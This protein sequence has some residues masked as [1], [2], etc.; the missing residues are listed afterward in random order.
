M[1]AGDIKKAKDAG[2]HTCNGMI[3][4]TKK[5]SAW[6]VRCLTALHTLADQ[7]GTSQLCARSQQLQEIKGLSEAKV[8]KLVRS[9]ALHSCSN[10]LCSSQAG[11][12]SCLMIC[13]AAGC[14]QEA[15]PLVRLPL[16][17]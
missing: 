12:S 3:M 9:A 13:C 8:E 6:H 5:V 2:Y 11:F 17:Q 10:E 4:Y 14:S 1:R 15:L 7:S 16:R